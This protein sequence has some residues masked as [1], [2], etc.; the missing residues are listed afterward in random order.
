[1]MRIAKKRLKQLFV[2][3]HV[4]K[5]TCYAHDGGYVSVC[6]YVIHFACISF[7]PS[8]SVGRAFPVCGVRQIQLRGSR[9]F[10]IMTWHAERVGWWW[11]WGGGMGEG[12]RKKGVF[13]LQQALFSLRSPGQ[14]TPAGS[15]FM[16]HTA[17][18]RGQSGTQKA[19]L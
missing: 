11:Q 7:R 14:N 13:S 16:M 9:S 2:F 5:R 18:R 4:F 3:V 6:D 19:V 17:W 12:R 10:L 8:R 15:H 1:M